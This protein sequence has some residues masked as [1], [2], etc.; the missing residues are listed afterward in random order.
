MMPRRWYREEIVLAMEWRAQGDPVWL[1]ALALGCS[2]HA[3][4]WNLR[5]ARELGLAAYPP[6]ECWA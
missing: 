6:R 1:V 3:V 4:Y 2:E 5:R